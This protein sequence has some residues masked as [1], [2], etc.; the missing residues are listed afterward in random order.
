M[1]ITV[2]GKDAKLDVKP[3]LVKMGDAV[4]YFSDLKERFWIKKKAAPLA[5]H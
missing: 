1:T 3:G 5:A 2:D 4:K